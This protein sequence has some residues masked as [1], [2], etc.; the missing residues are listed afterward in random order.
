VIIRNNLGMTESIETLL[1]QQRRLDQVANNIANVD[2]A[3]FKREDVT[4]W[5]MLY[6]ASDN[7]QRVGKGIRPLTDQSQG[8]MQQTGNPLDVAINGDGFFKVQTPDG[9]RYTR[10]GNFLRNEQ[11]QLVTPAGDLVLSDG[12]TIVLSR[13]VVGIGR[14]GRIFQDGNVVAQLAV[15][16][17]DELGAL[18]R[19]GTNLFRLKEGEGDEVVPERVD[20]Q[21]GYLEESNVQTIV[22]MTEMIDL[23]RDYEALQKAIQS[24]DDING[25]AVARV[26]KLTG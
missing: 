14:D 19:E 24:L 11:G 5:E 10:A 16:T 23:S 8:S 4:F 13:E 1:A 6:T 15:V 7:R 26:G 22:E 20:V 18:E 2:T 3:G 9:E 12:G 21:Q 25:Q 17:F